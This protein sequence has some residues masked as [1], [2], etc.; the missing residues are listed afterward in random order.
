ME[1]KNKDYTVRLKDRYVKEIVPAMQKRFNY[2]NAMQVP[3]LEKIAI[4]I[5]VGEATQDGKFLE[6][7]VQDLQAITGQK[8]VITKARKSI[9]NFKLRAGVAIGCRVTLRRA[10]MYEFLDRFLNV[11]VPRIRDFRGMDDRGFDGRGNFTMGIREQ[12][13][14]PEINYDKVLKIRG[15]NV[16]IVTTA[17]TDEEAYELL[18][19]FGMPFRKREK[20][21]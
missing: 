20:A 10:M 13:I 3:R 18:K 11:A 1:K 19:E 12:I 14:F 21:A 15:F 16:T 7:A 6:A 17:E 5:G 9:S 4:N 2:K 8:A